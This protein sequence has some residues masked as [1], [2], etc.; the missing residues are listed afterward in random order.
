[1]DRGPNQIN[2]EVASKESKLYKLF[3]SQDFH[4]FSHMSLSVSFS[5]RYSL[6]SIFTLVGLGSTRT[7]LNYPLALQETQ[8]DFRL[9]T[10]PLEKVS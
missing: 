2:Y 9:R 10:V 7:L 3:S 8:N 6:W 1:M 4:M 5:Y